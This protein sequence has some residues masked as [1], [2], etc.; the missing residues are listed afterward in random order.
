MNQEEEN[1]LD[2]NDQLLTIKCQ[3]IKTITIRE[4]FLTITSTKLMYF[5]YYSIPFTTD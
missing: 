5:L 3:C 2:E 4:G 1:I